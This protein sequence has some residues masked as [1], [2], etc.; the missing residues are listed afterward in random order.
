M[1]QAQSENK[2]ARGAPENKTAK[3]RVKMRVGGLMGRVLALD[4]PLADTLVRDGKAEF[5]A[6][7][8]TAEGSE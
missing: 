1:N 5:L 7:E 4:K 3:V 8:K 2:A 6:E